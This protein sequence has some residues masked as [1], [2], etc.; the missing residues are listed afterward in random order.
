MS[1]NNFE[2]TSRRSMPVL[3]L[4][5]L[6]V[7]PGML[8]NFDVERPMSAAALN[9]AMNADQILFLAAQKEISKDVP[10]VDDIYKIGTV[11]RVRQMLRQPGSKTVRVMVE[12]LAR[13]RI[14][15]VTMDTPSLFAEIEPMPDAPEKP[16]VKTEALCRRCTALFSEYAQISGNI[17][18]ESVINIMASTDAAY[19]ADFIA[20]NIYLKPE[21]KQKL[22]EELRPSR[23]LASLCRMLTRE[24]TLLSIE[25]DLNESTQE[26]MNRNQREYYLR[27]QMKVIQSELGEDDMPQELD[28]YREKIKALGLEKETEEKLL[29]EVTRLSRQ[30][31]GSAEASVIRG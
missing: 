5:G 21:E 2:F 31:F 10:F 27:E 17:A 19:V 9:F 16:T 8:L 18:P 7:F 20:Q 4:R 26:Q 12:G 22:L 29:K 23:R 11:C 6:S 15:A 3:P 30:S 28:D 25:R 24:L 14:D 13:G 1:S